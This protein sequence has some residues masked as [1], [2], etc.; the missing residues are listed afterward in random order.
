[1]TGPAKRFEVAHVV[2]ATIG[3]SDDVVNGLCGRDQIVALAVL[4]QMFVPS[5]HGG[6]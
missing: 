4:A 3:L 5:K 2:R 6:S 1:M